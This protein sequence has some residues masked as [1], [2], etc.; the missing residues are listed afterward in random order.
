MRI[1]QER[2][3]SV[4]SSVLQ[5]E[6][7]AKALNLV[8][9]PGHADFSE[10]T[11][12]TLAAVDSAVMLMD[13]AKGVEPRTRKLFEVC[14]MRKLRDYLHEQLDRHGLDARAHRP[15]ADRSISTWRPQLA[16]GDGRG[17]PRCRGN[18]EP[19]SHLYDP[20]LGEGNRDVSSEGSPGPR[21]SPP[22]GRRATHLEMELIEHAGIPTTAIAS[23]GVSPLFGARR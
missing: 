7:E 1:E 21:R 8:D 10:D 17:V 14:R 18:E 16:A 2:G 20:R 19:R 12:R 13:H 6:H 5:F 23:T 15:S 22:R 9:T 11:F 4:T 3:I